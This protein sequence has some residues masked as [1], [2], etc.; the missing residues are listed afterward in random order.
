MSNMMTLQ[1]HMGFK[2]SIV[3]YQDTLVVVVDATLFYNG[4]YRSIQA[5]LGQGQHMQR[6][7]GGTMN[8]SHDVEDNAV[9]L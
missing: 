5:T 6:C 4:S 9:A 7:Y 1:I 8:I 2:D 3:A